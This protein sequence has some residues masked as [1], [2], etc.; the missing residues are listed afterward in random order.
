MVPMRRDGVSLHHRLA[1]LQPR[2]QRRVRPKFWATSTTQSN[3]AP[4][5]GLGRRTG[6]RTR[7]SFPTRAVAG[8]SSGEKSPLVVMFS[9]PVSVPSVVLPMFMFALPVPGGVMPMLASFLDVM[10]PS[11]G[12]PIV[13]RMHLHPMSFDPDMPV[14]IPGPIPRRPHKTRARRWSDIHSRR[15][16]RDFDAEAEVRLSKTRKGRSP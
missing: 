3:M 7:P 9:T 5:Y 6:V 4:S 2:K 16:W 14:A 10:L 13:A 8:T 11:V 1:R 15:W 12:Y